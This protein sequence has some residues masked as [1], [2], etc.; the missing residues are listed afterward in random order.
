MNFLVLTLALAQTP[1][2]ANAAEPQQQPAATADTAEKPQSNVVRV[3]TTDDP[4][5]QIGLL[6]RCPVCQGMPISDSPS[7]TAQAMMRRVRELVAEGKPRDE[8]LA[9]FKKSYGEWAVLE[10]ERKGINWL[11]WL[12]P[13]G[14]V[15]IGIWVFLGYLRRTKKPQPGQTKKSDKPEDTEDEY[16][17][18]DRE[19]VQL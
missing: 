15:L 9:Y 17:R 1:D 8:I 7:D 13:P 6:L 16:L 5:Y 3:E 4:A 10:P 19:E 14:G 2:A 11:V 12:L 18:A